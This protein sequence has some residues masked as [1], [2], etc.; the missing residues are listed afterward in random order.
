[1]GEAGAHVDNF[2]GPEVYYSSLGT[3]GFLRLFM[4]MGCVIRHVE[5]DQYP[6]LHTY[7]I[8]EKG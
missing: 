8:I 2:M 5:F 1:M 4:E 6:E 3:Q 7:M